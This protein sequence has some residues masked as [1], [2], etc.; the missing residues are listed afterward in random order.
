VYIVHILKKNIAVSDTAP[1][2][3][4]GAVFSAPKVQNRINLNLGAKLEQMILIRKY[5]NAKT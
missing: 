1:K 5:Y 4:G 2:S 3:R